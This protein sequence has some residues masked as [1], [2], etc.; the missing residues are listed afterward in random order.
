MK[1]EANPPKKPLLPLKDAVKALDEQLPFDIAVGILHFLSEI[2]L[3]AVDQ[4]D[5]VQERTSA[6]RITRTDFISSTD[7]ALLCS[8]LPTLIKPQFL[9]GLPRPLDSIDSPTQI[10]SRLLDTIARLALEPAFTFVIAK[11]FGRIL[12]DLAGRW[13]L[14]LGFGRK[15]FTVPLVEKQTVFAVLTAIARLLNLYPPLYP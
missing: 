11:A 8:V 13:L 10:K 14:L 15:T 4:G 1:A 6:L 9:A 3:W 7:L 12:L 5:V 2:G